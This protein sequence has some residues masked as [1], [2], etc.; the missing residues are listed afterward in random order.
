[1]PERRQLEW[2]DLHKDVSGVLIMEPEF[3]ANNRRALVDALKGGLVIVAANA[4]IQQRSDMAYPFVQESNF[5]YLSGI[6]EP[7]WLIV[8]DGSRGHSWLVAPDVSDVHRTFDG[9]LSND[10]AKQISAADE[11]ITRDEYLELL[12]RLSKSHR[13]VYT[14]S[15]PSSVEYYNFE[16]NPSLDRHKQMLARYFSAVQDC[17][18]EL[19]ALRAIKQA[20][21]ISCIQKAV[22]ISVDGFKSIHATLSSYKA[23]YEIEADFAHSVRRAGADGCAYESIVASGYN[24]CTLHY[25]ANSA[26]IAA[27]QLVLMDMGAQ[28]KGYAAD[29]TRTYMKGEPTK[30]QRDVHAAVEAAHLQI[31]DLIAPMVS[32]ESYQKDVDTIMSKALESIGLPSD[33]EGLRRYFPHAI[34]HGLGIDVHDSLGRPKFFQENMV[35]TVEPGI[36]IPEE[37]I[38]VRIEDDIIVSGSGRI[39]LS[40]KLSTGL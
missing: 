30:R 17:R 26:K 28:Y 40:A 21:E 6:D 39:N 34:S 8:I 13:L 22:S 1:M 2:H 33:E 25:S 24:A 12:R 19:S 38:G 5:L 7:D 9:G 3:Y 31:I 32:V 35:L 16:L 4:R 18:T 29:I 27:R 36:Y 15:Q 14:L 11:V 20:A 10:E 23:E 37:K